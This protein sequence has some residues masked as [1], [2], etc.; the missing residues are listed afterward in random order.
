MGA[1][2]GRSPVSATSARPD[3]ALVAELAALELALA[4]RELAALPGGLE[5]VLDDGFLEIGASGRRWDRAST[6]KSVEAAPPGD[7]TIDSLTATSVA[8]DVILVTYRA[9]VPRPDGEARVALRSSIWV[10]RGQRWR[11]RFH[12][13]TPLPG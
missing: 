8:A 5:Q 6:M 4:R 10:R 12:Q 13:A 3:P 1:S 7:V 9:F 11:I 2:G